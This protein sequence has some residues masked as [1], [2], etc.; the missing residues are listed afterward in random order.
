M[1]KENNGALSFLEKKH[2]GVVEFRKS[3]NPQNILILYNNF[4]K[5]KIKSF[6]FFYY[7][8]SNSSENSFL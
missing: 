6:S 5:A 7:N 1:L 8:F 3:Y 2:N 4:L